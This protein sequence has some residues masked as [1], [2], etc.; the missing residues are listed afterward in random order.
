MS[1]KHGIDDHITACQCKMILAIREEL[2]NVACST[3]RWL[4][5]WFGTSFE[6]DGWCCP[7]FVV[8]VIAATTGNKRIGT[9]EG[10]IMVLRST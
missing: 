4:A 3:R 2:M 7:N 10:Q 8:L 5:T 9:S 6:A 1:C